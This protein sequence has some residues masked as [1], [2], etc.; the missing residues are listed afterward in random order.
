MSSVFQVG[1][2]GGYILEADEAK[3]RIAVN[4]LRGNAVE[5]DATFPHQVVL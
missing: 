2:T 3:V 1:E 4:S 5:D